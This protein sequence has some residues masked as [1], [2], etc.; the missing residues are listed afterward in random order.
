MVSIGRPTPSVGAVTVLPRVSS[1]TSTVTVDVKIREET[2][3]FLQHG[4][5][6]EVSRTQEHT[7]PRTLHWTR[8]PAPRPPTTAEVG[9]RRAEKSTATDGRL[10][11]LAHS[12]AK[13]RNACGAR[14]CYLPPPLHP[15]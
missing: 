5:V 10:T 15:P 1:R 14:P 11:A 4:T 2:D 12:I 6:H 13:Q 9:S 8:K 7:A 3:A